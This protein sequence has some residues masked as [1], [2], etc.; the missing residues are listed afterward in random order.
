MEVIIV[1]LVLLVAFV[2]IGN[3]LYNQQ[4]KAAKKSSLE[5]DETNHVVLLWIKYFGTKECVEL[6][7]KSIELDKKSGV[8]FGETAFAD[9]FANSIPAG[10][11]TNIRNAAHSVL[12]DILK[13]HP[14][15]D[16]I[17]ACSRLAF[18]VKEMTEKGSTEEE[19]MRS[20]MRSF[21]KP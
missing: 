18:M 4:Q 16:R 11:N 5:V 8:D 1:V 14:N 3:L 17:Q 15:A 12:D 7:K 13:K 2:V 6:I 21:Q 10:R 9:M 19:V 20:V